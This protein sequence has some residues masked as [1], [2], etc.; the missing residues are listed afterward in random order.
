MTKTQDKSHNK[1]SQYARLERLRL[2]TGKTWQQIADALK[3]DRSMLFH[4]K[5]GARNLSDK[6]LFRLREAELAAGINYS[7]RELIDFGLTSQQTAAAVLEREPAGQD[8][9]TK[10]DISR[11]LVK[12]PLKYKLGEVP[13]D[14]PS[15]L[16]VTSPPNEQV[17]SIAHDVRS[18]LRQPGPLLALCLPQQQANREFLD[19]LTPSCYK[20]VVEAAMALT[21]GINWKDEIRGI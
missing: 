12:V 8:M 4:V 6:A 15:T 16:D 7:T 1:S 21:F 19:Q 13:K 18:L 11:G 14:H 10:G 9:V 2:V 17:M 20:N 5:S 3:V